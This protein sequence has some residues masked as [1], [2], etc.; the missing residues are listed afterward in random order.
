M[1]QGKKFYNSRVIDFK[2]HESE[3]YSWQLI[4]IKTDSIS[5][6]AAI[7]IDLEL[8]FELENLPDEVL[9]ELDTVERAIEYIYQKLNRK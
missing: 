3:Y 6:G 4:A 9:F 5:D 7:A 1:I 8:E 2:P